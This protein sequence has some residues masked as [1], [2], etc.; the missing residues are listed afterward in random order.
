MAQVTVQF[1]TQNDLGG[2]AI[3]LFEHG[4]YSHVDIVLPDGMLLGASSDVYV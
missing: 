2:Q 3:R 4:A 1:S